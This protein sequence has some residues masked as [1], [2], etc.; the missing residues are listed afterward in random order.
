LIDDRRWMIV[1]PNGRFVTQRQ[2]P[3]MALISTLLDDRGLTLSSPQLAPNESITVALDAQGEQLPG[4]IWRDQCQLMDV[5][6]AAGAWLS[7]VLTSPQPLNLVTMAPKFER[8]QSQTERFGDAAA[9]FADAAPYLIANRDSL[10]ILNQLLEA[11]DHPPVTMERFRPNIVVEG[12]GPFKEHDY[13]RLHCSGGNYTLQ[14]HD[15]C[16]RCI[17][18]TNDPESGVMHPHKEPYP[19][20]ARL[21]PNPDNKIAPVFGV[22]A[23][24]S[25]GEN[26]CIGVGDWVSV[27][28]DLY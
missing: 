12:L 9:I 17:V 3:K 23:S 10:E 11:E 22:N 24:L 6:P 4:T 15:H 16:E 7:K 14:L 13:R 21:N 28:K 1:M 5:S 25:D 2:L 27:D 8:Q 18:I 20:L 19:T 26:I